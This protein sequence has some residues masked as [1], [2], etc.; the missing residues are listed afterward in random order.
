MLIINCKDISAC[1][2]RS[3]R[4]GISLAASTVWHCKRLENSDGPNSAG[5]LQVIENQAIRLDHGTE[6]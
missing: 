6:Y 3:G 2:T 4:V 1:L 5:F